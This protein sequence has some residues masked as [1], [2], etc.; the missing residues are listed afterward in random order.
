MKNKDVKIIILEDEPAHAELIRRNLT[1]SQNG[2]N[3]TVA[4]TL[5]EFRQIV[6]YVQ[7]DLVI[8]DMNLPDGNAL[9]LLQGSVESQPWPVLLMTSFGDEELAVRALKS[10]AMD[11]MVKSPE[12]IKNIRYVVNRNIREWR[13]IRKSRLAE[14]AMRE[15]EKKFRTLFETM[16]QGVVYHDADGSIFEANPAALKILG[17][18]LAQ[19]KNRNSID[20]RWRAIHEDGSPFP[21]ET[22]PAY[23]SLQTGQEVKDVVMGV[24]HPQLNDYRWLMVN[25]I[26]QFHEGEDKPYQVFTSF[27]DITELKQTQ[28]MLQRQNEEL[29][30]AKEKAEESDRLKSAFMANMS[31][32]IRTPMNGILGFADLLKAP[33][34]SG[35]SQKKFIEIIELSGRRMLDIINDL[36]DISKIE[37][38]QVEINKER[39]H[40]GDLMDELLDFFTPEAKRR[41][42][43]MSCRVNLP[44]SML[45]IR[46]DRTKLAQIITNLIKNAL[47]FTGKG[48]YITFGC[49]VQDKNHIYF[50]VEDNGRGIR[51]ELQEKIFDRFRQGEVSQTEIHE[52]VGLGLSITKA[53]VEM[54]G[55]EIGVDSEPDR[56]SEFYFSLPYKKQESSAETKSEEDDSDSAASFPCVNILIAEDDQPSYLLLKE[57]LLQNNINSY[58]VSN[59]RDAVEMIKDHSDINLVLMDVKMPVMDGLEATREIKKVRAEVPVIAQSA[60]ASESNIRNALEAGCSDYITKPIRIN[61]LLSKIAEHCRI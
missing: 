12:A 5:S 56:G 57:I 17:L 38:G 59:G 26:P 18:S 47:K 52:G 7:P 6:S 58:H 1:D 42:I 8:A 31:H 36:I 37:S 41:E 50:W 32:E 4:G 60:F 33:N 10:G 54:L 27:T 49:S 29:K 11:Y 20:P 2:C 30:A 21:G 40:I 34:L 43:R 44:S 3:I 13:N 45:Y 22:R 19:I 48:G 9:S 53:L 23:I 24:F 39:F 15:S 51:K 46:T 61:V 16:A 28:E 55:G 14:I 35:E 25:S